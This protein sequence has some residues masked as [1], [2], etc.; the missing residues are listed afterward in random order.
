VLWAMIK[1][2]EGYLSTGSEGLESR[3]DNQEGRV[4][5]TVWTKR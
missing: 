4:E 2:N 5:S 1:G 3:S